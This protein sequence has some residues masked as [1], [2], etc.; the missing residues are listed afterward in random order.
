MRSP[1]V[2]LGVDDPN[3]TRADDDVVEIGSRARD[4]SV[5]QHPHRWTDQCVETLAQSFFTVCAY[6]PGFGALRLVGD[7]QNQPTEVRMLGPYAFLA[8]RTTAFELAAS[9]CSRYADSG[10][11]SRV[12]AVGRFTA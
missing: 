5:M 1:L 4:P 12:L 6:S 3:A 2:L 8:R 11:A 10:A 9:G 7:R